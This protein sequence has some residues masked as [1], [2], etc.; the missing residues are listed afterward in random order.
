MDAVAPA[1]APFPVSAATP[2]APAPRVEA[3]GEP[4][5]ADVLGAANTMLA[6]SRR[7]RFDA[8][9]VALSQSPSGRT[10]SPAARA[11]RALALAGR[12]DDAPA[13]AF[14]RAATVW[15][16]LPVVYATEGMSTEEAVHT[17]A[18][19]GANTPRGI[20]ARAS[21]RR[22]GLGLA[23][24]LVAPD[25][26]PGLS[27][28]ASR[29]GEALGG[30]V[31]AVSVPATPVGSTSTAASSSAASSLPFVS[32]RAPSAAQEMVQTGRPSGRHGG[33]ET[34][35][36]PWFEAAARKMLGERMGTET[37]SMAELTLVN[38]APPTQIAASSMVSSPK[39]APAAP[40][41][42]AGGT[43]GK[44]DDADIDAIAEEVYK[45]VINMMDAA[46]ARNGEPYL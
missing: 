12:G 6:A 29:A 39:A 40:G 22:P 26:R 14:E 34:E 37:L 19:L 15:D 17:Q 33:G 2:A 24:E 10:M 44:K 41:A 25:S 38:A 13:S 23:P 4:G 27:P 1:S 11:A 7:A 20:A 8:L 46:R 43:D 45:A 18:E 16:V 31:T 3:Q 42:S 36:P 30:Y 9:Y 21:L 32:Q 28:L 35:I 5:E